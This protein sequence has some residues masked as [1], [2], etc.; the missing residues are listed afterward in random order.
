[1]S[2]APVVVN[3]PGDFPV[4]GSS[5]PSDFVRFTPL[6]A[7]SEVGRSCHILQYKGKTIM[8]DCGIHPAGSGIAA[9]PFL[10]EIDLSTVDMLLVSHFH[11][12]HAAA[13]PHLLEKTDF[14]GRVFMTHPTKSIYKL[15]LLDYVKVSTISIEETLYDEKDLLNS[16]D[17]IECIN[18]HEVVHYKGIK[19]WCYN[20]GHVLGAAMFMIEIAGIKILYTGDYSRSE[21]RHLNCA[22]LPEVKPDIL[23]IESTYG[24]Q[25]LSPVAQREKLFTDFVHQIIRRGGRVLIPVFA[26]GRAQELLLILDEYWDANPALQDY[27]I[28]Y[29]SALAKKCMLVY[30]TYIHMMNKHIQQQFEISNPFVFKHISNLKSMDKF[31]DIGPSVVM[32]SPGMLQNGLSRE[33]FELWC[34]DPKNGCI[35]PGY[36]V[37]GT[38]AKTIMSEPQTIKTMSGLDVPLKMSIHYVSFSA[39]ADYAE[40]SS[41]IDALKPPHVI[42]V[43]GEANEMGRLKGALL[44]TYTDGSIVI[45]SP[46]NCQTVEIEFRQEKVAKI[47]GKLTKTL[48]VDENVEDEILQTRGAGLRD[49]DVV[50]GL[51]VRKNFNDQII[52]V[53]ELSTYTPVAATNITQTLKVPFMHTF[54]LLKHYLGQIYDIDEE[55][56]EISNFGNNEDEEEEQ[57]A[58]ARCLSVMD[59]VNVTHRVH[60]QENKR[61]QGH[62]LL[63]WDSNPVSDMVADSI[64]SL[65]MGIDT[66]PAAAKL[67][68]QPCKHHHRPENESSVGMEPTP[69]KARTEKDHETKLLVDYLASHFGEGVVHV[70]HSRRIEVAFDDNHAFFDPENNEISGDDETLASRVSDIIKLARMSLSTCSMFDTNR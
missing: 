66:S 24:V 69:K 56:S 52:S 57:Q 41:F 17:K 67:L 19:F 2:A 26:L 40:T 34:S 6:G 16:M 25:T 21:D 28:Y 23:I 49:G 38:L 5:D 47:V 13:L 58:S 39:H 48:G 46:K 64:I 1:M 37:E 65:L 22:E 42:L 30:Q 55:V 7:G 44:R 8:L 61:S 36:S 15:I 10:D 63:E 3:G 54:E 14:K 11:L 33:L 35:I 32:A 68:S 27:P 45:S 29:A 59:C 60:D 51:F 12:D 53:E 70:D 43:H 18:F 4:P 31:D 20:A 50:S 9:L 62:V